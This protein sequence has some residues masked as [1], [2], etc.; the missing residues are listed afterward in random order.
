MT[1]YTDV[2]RKRTYLEAG[3]SNDNDD[4]ASEAV[5]DVASRPADASEKPK[6]KRKRSEGAKNS[7]SEGVATTPDETRKERG[8]I[9]DRKEENNQAKKMKKSK[10]R[11]TAAKKG[12]RASLHMS[13]TRLI[14]I[15]HVD[16]TSRSEARRIKRIRE[17]D[18]NT[19]CFACREK[20][21]AAR[22][23]RNVKPE[24][25]NSGKGSKK[26]VGIC[27]QYVP[28]IFSYKL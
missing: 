11:S 8:E 12:T 24:G 17:R 13:Y 10:S 23:C 26:V 7:G 28:I 18:A 3:F 9:E 1:R 15:I 6:K 14:C 5:E 4:V 21:H 20:G 27:Y 16:A 22:D 2:G 19:I 25:E